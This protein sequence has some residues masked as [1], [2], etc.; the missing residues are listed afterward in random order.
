[1]VA[2]LGFGT[3]GQLGALQEA[4]AWA[5]MDRLNDESSDRCWWCSGVGYRKYMLRGSRDTHVEICGHCE[6]SGLD[7]ELGVAG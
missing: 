6:G 7:V 1:M 3:V 2:F 5:A 4:G